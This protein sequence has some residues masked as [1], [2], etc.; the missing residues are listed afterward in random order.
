M[1]KLKEEKKQIIRFML[2]MVLSYIGING[3]TTYIYYQNYHNSINIMAQILGDSDTEKTDIVFKILK[4]NPMDFVAKGKQLLK[5][6]GYLV[7]NENALF[8]RFYQ[9]CLVTAIITFILFTIVSILL[10]RWQKSV[11][12][13][14]RARLN[15]IEKTIV[16]FR[17]NKLEV[18][19]QEDDLEEQ[20]K[21]EFQLDALGNHL[22]LLK[23]EARLEREGTKELV[24]DISHQLKT[25]VAALDT[26]F[27]VLLRENLN[28]EEQKEFFARCRNALDGLE[29]LL[30]SLLQISKLESGMIQI[31]K[32][33]VPILDTIVTAV[34]RVYPKALEKNI[35]LVFDYNEELEDYVIVQDKKWLSEAIINVLDNAIKYS[36]SNSE[37]FVRLQKRYG[38]VRI[39][40]EDHG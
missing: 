22:K 13:A 30:Q 2:I 16:N 3:L 18:F 31:E 1:K 21:I 26:C 19:L 8:E 9:E 33:K 34:N 25:P 38:F 36:P 27:S 35:E 29:V 14:Q 7:N 28:Q 24:S 11:W 23:E 12:R 15:Q 32:C 6:Y 40:I 39:E 4:S 5:Q 10:L 20:E 17:E 37:V